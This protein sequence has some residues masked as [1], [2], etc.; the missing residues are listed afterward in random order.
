MIADTEPRQV[1]WTELVRADGLKVAI[2]EE[3][4]RLG[5]WPMSDDAGDRTAAA[6]ADLRLRSDELE[7]I[8]REI[9][10]LEARQAYWSDPMALVTEIQRRRH[11]RIRA[12]RAARR[13]E[14]RRRTEEQRREKLEQRRTTLPFLGRGVSVGLHFEGGDRPRLET[15]G[16]P[17]L[18]TATDVAEA[19]GVTV[20]ELAWL[21]YRREA[22]DLDH[23]HRFLIPKRGGGTRL[24]SSPKSK[25][26]IAQSW[27]LHAVLEKLAV[28]HA[29]MAFRP[30][31]SILDNAALHSG[32]G[33]VIR[34]DL[35]DFFGT[36][37]F[38]RVKGLFESFG[39]NEGV[40]T[41]LAL[42]A[43]EVPRVAAT[44]DG[45]P[46]FIALGKGQ[47]PQGASTSPSIVN[48]L[49]RSLDR[50]LTGVARLHGFTYSRYCDDLVFSHP[51]RGTALGSLL[52]MIEQVIKDES[53]TVNESKTAVMRPQ[54]RQV[55]TGLV[56]N[57]EPRISR[58]DLRRFRAFLHHCETD[59]LKVTSERLGRDALA[60]ATGYL[61]HIQM[62]QPARARQ[63]RAAYP[64]IGDRRDP[65]R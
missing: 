25:L 58:N 29:A 16:L 56:V 19:I 34:I 15:L 59:G 12:N 38:R 20:S 46:V 26:R 13:E 43:T 44:L 2:S 24:I 45:K 57:Q 6:L 64:W 23:Y 30:G 47:L 61:S 49:C 36:V 60:Y 32:K 7:R 8:D 40:A 10:T 4:R 52:G 37:L 21:T 63:V 48:V 65:T 22:A 55:V 50:R 39:Y 28:H 17:I 33:V 53:F 27:L 11:E 9:D 35:K 3:M 1:F 14:Q 62:V 31:V 51:E 42:L 18:E 54:H 5:F 41:I